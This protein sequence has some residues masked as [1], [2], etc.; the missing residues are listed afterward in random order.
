VAQQDTWL[1]RQLIRWLCIELPDAGDG[2]ARHSDGASSPCAMD[3]HE[4]SARSSCLHV[5]AQPPARLARALPSSSQR[6]HDFDARSEAA[7]TR[8]TR[9]LPQPALRKPRPETSAGARWR[10]H[11]VD[12]NFLQDLARVADFLGLRQ[13][14]TSP[15]PRT[16]VQG[17][18]SAPI[19]PRQPTPVDPLPYERRGQ[20]IG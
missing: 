10:W 15:L 8:A 7:L 1:A 18:L 6:L 17:R 12:L 11:T 5:P 9:S 14:P 16:Q 20:P 4:P 13:G 2:G 19:R 3:A